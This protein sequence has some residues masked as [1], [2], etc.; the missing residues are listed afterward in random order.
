MNK[1]VILFPAVLVLILATAHPVS[2]LEAIIDS[3]G[4]ITFYNDGVLG[5]SIEGEDAVKEQELE[6]KSREMQERHQQELS[7]QRGSETETLRKQ[8]TLEKSQL[9]RETEAFRKQQIE[10]ATRE[11]NSSAVRRVTSQEEKELRIRQEG[12]GAS[13][14][15]RDKNGKEERMTDGTDSGRIRVE[16]LATPRENL[17]EEQLKEIGSRNAEVRLKERAER[18]GEKVELRQS[19]DGVEGLELK[20]RD[21]AAKIA[22]RVELSVDPETNELSIINQNGEVIKVIHLPDQAITRME[23]LGALDPSQE[24]DSGQLQIDTNSQG[25]V[26]YKLI[27]NNKLKLFGIFNRDV[28]TEVELNDETGLTEENPV[29]RGGFQGFLDRFTF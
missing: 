2:A 26:V 6:R 27:K 16:L 28:E 22:N 13:M 20:S 18:I 29:Q 23:E 21:V 17:T 8:Q 10:S 24:T 14:L 12:D 11:T 5:D 3:K 15:L 25:Q 19:E 1:K 7:E 4:T 9:Q